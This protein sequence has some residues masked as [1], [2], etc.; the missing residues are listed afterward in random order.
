MLIFYTIELIISTISCAVFLLK[1]TDCKL[2]TKRILIYFFV[3]FIPAYIVF[4]NFDLLLL[5]SLFVPYSF[6]IFAVG[7]ISKKICVFMV[8]FFQ[9]ISFALTSAIILIENF[10]VTENIYKSIIDIAIEIC[11]LLV[12]LFIKEEYIQLKF[13]YFMEFIPNGLKAFIV[14]SLYV[15]ALFAFGLSYIPATEFIDQ[16]WYYFLEFSFILSLIVFCVVYPIFI[17]S[18]TSRNYYKKISEI[19]NEQ[20]KQQY[21]YYQKLME[22]EQSLREF[23]HD[24]KNQLIVLKAFWDKKDLLSAQNYLSDSFNFIDEISGIQTGNYVLDVLLSDKK[25]TAKDIKFD[26]RGYIS[27]E[28]VEPI[29]ICTIF[30]NALDNAIE[31]CKR[32]DIADKTIKISLVENVS[33]IHICISNPV[34]KP[35]RIVNN[36]I[37]TTKKD[38]INH[39]LGLYSIKKSVEKYNGSVHLKCSDNLFSINILLANIDVD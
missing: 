8:A 28:F 7:D 17:S 38:K 10:F 2:L 12:L 30:G 33:T 16:I 1:T 20:S 9:A 19:T 5:L 6:I 32:T 39:G 31:A 25:K 37:S 26:V 27:A 15:I 24:Y 34:Y 21:I 14:I 3:I 36:R 4:V 11:I 18:I 23:K 13:N 29:D 35:V 22:K